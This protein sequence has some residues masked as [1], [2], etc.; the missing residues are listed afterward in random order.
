M[1]IAKKVLL[2]FIGLI[3]L[4]AALMV[5]LQIYYKLT[6]SALSPETVQLNARA[7]LLPTVTENGYRPH[8]LLA[9]GT[10]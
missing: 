6:P 10:S 2:W 8:G 1:K 3:A 9:P 4:T 7:A 5:G